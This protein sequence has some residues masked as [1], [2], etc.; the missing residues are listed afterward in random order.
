MFLYKKNLTVLRVARL[1]GTPVYQAMHIHITVID[2]PGAPIYCP[3]IFRPCPQFCYRRDD[4]TKQPTPGNVNVA[5]VH[6]TCY[7]F[8]SIKFALLPQIKIVYKSGNSDLG[9]C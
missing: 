6:Y 3:A 5:G 9:F 7:V 4:L 2:E 1:V 8:G